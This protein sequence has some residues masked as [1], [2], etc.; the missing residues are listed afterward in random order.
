MVLL[1]RNDS[2]TAHCGYCCH[3]RIV[4]VARDLSPTKMGK[5]S[6]NSVASCSGSTGSEEF[7]SADVRFRGN[8]PRRHENLSNQLRR[9]S[10][11][12]RSAEQVGRGRI[13][14]ARPAIRPSPTHLTERRDVFDRAG[15]NSL[16]RNGIVERPDVGGRDVES[17]IVSEQHAVV[18]TGN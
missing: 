7:K 9:L 15:W 14:S 12:F 11:R 16:F 2:G 8:A 13:L 3:H 18:A 6:R 17:R 4:A 1:W 5:H 10:W